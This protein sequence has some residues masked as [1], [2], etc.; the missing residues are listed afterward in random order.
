MKPVT[1][2]SD[3]LALSPEPTVAQLMQ[4][5]IASGITESSVAVLERMMDLKERMDAKAAE[6][7]FNR[8]FVSL[9]Q[10]IPVIVASSEIPSRGKYE[11]FEDVMR[12]VGPLLTKHG[13][14]VSFAMTAEVNRITET[15]HLRHRDGHSSVNA[16]SVRVGGRADSETQADCKAATTAKRNALLNCLNIVIRQD[17]YQNEDGDDARIEGAPIS[18]EQAQTLRELVKDTASNEAAFLAYA[19]AKTY[20]EIGS[21]KYDLLFRSLNA[22]RNRKP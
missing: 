10:D 8:A 3:A 12:V 1:E 20:E 7:A 22:K 15:C 13:F 16:F 5:V 18:F 4:A 11:R 2:T 14:S 21:A 6:L 17:V 19:G 9:Q